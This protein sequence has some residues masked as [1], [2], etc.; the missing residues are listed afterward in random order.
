M[1]DLSRVFAFADITMTLSALVNLI[2]L[3][4]L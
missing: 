3:T 2:A 1:E 4:L